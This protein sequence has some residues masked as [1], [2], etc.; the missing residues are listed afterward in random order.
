LI[1]E[2]HPLKGSQWQRPSEGLLLSLCRLGCDLIC[3]LQKMWNKGYSLTLYLFLMLRFLWFWR[4]FECVGFYFRFGFSIS[5]I[6]PAWINK[7]TKDAKDDCWNKGS[8]NS[9]ERVCSSLLRQW[10]LLE[11]QE[12][13]NVECWL[14][15]VNA[16]MCFFEF[17]GLH[18]C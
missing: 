15:R 6:V 18:W 2:L 8:R 3:S 11:M 12:W 16:G 17:R 14:W 10:Y 13:V 7:V 5:C 4:N 1:F 9:H